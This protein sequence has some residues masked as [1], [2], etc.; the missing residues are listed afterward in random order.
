MK[1]NSIRCPEG[2]QIVSRIY[3]N[4]FDTLIKAIPRIRN[5][6]WGSGG[7]EGQTT[8][9]QMLREEKTKANGG[10]YDNMGKIKKSQKII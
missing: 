10:I 9:A 8:E 3:F 1:E 5:Q 2:T 4:I 6:R 7:I